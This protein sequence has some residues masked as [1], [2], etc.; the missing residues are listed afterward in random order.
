MKQFLLCLALLVGLASYA[1][2]TG[3][4]QCVLPKCAPNTWVKIPGKV[5][6]GEP[7]QVNLSAIATQAGKFSFVV[8]IYVNKNQ[9][10]HLAFNNV[11]LSADELKVLTDWWTPW[12]IGVHY[13]HVRTYTYK[14]GC[15]VRN[16]SKIVKIPVKGPS[17]Q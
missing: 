6:A 15:H 16:S 13:A 10:G 8:D 1:Q 14:E 7:A 11:S 4:T 2:A 3:D 5:V 9:V 12:E 17:C